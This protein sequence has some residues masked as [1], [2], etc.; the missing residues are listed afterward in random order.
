MTDRAALTRWIDGYQRAWRSNDPAEI[1]ALFAVDG[2]YLT[3]PYADPIAG[4]DA[5]VEFWLEGRDEPGDWAFAW[6]P[7]A[8]EG[9]TAVIQA[10]TDYAGKSDYFNIWVIRFAPDGTAA[11]FT[12]WYMVD[13]G[14]A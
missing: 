12:E 3:E 1:G 2:V 7:V 13:D 10:K 8:I 11:S 4:R 6:H 14:D 9:D 5:I